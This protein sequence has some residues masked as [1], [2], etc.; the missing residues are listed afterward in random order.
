MSAAKRKILFD[1]RC[2]ATPGPTAT[3]TAALVRAI[4]RQLDENEELHVIVP[5][6]SNLRF[7][8]NEGQV[9]RHICNAAPGTIA[10]RIRTLYITVRVQPDVIHA[11]DGI[12]SPGFRRINRPM[13]SGVDW[14][15]FAPIGETSANAIRARH[16]LPEKYLL[17]FVPT[18]D[19]TRNVDTIVNAISL[20]DS[21]ETLPVVMVGVQKHDSIRRVI[22]KRGLDDCFFCLESISEDDRPA[23][24]ASAV[25]YLQTDLDDKNHNDVIEAMACGT[26][27]L[28][29]ALPQSRKSFRN[30]AR[31]VHPTDPMEWARAIRAAQISLD[32]HDQAAA[33]GLE[34]AKK[35]SWTK[36]AAEYLAL[37]R[38]RYRHSLWFFGHK[39]KKS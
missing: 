15:R 2:I 6:N 36:I 9:F 22:E 13:L 35:R 26:P 10:G 39:N 16:H 23:L 24:M 30:I 38:R 28:L 8:K 27:V 18:D 29:A 14:H 1:A 19:K 34:L 20:M 11:P 12:K 31:L 32:W 3:R 33:R 37:Y 4:A 25:L 17:T 7:T 5:S 21:T